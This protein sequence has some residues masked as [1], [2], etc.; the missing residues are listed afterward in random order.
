MVVELSSCYCGPDWPELALVPRNPLCVPP[1]IGADGVTHVGEL[2]P[3]SMDNVVVVPTLI[4]VDHP[5]RILRERLLLLFGWLVGWQVW[6]GWWV[7]SIAVQ[8]SE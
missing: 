1:R 4:C 5:P 8:C 6:V 2:C 3:R 7:G